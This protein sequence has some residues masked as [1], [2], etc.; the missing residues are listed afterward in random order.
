MQEYETI[1][2]SNRYFSTFTF[3]IKQIQ[4]R[5][6]LQMAVQNRLARAEEVPEEAT[7]LAQVD[8]N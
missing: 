3:F 7:G 1:I 2:H 5:H 6:E 8:T 4:E